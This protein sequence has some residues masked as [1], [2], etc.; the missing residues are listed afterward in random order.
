MKKKPTIVENFNRLAKIT[1]PARRFATRL[2]RPKPLMIAGVCLLLVSAVCLHADD[3]RTWTSRSGATVDASFVKK[4]RGFIE[5]K[6]DTGKRL[7]IRV[8]DLSQDDREYIHGNK[9]DT[10]QP[11]LK[12]HSEK[13][14][15]NNSKGTEKKEKKAKK[16]GND[17][18]PLSL[19]IRQRAAN[20]KARQLERQSE[21]RHEKAEITQER[22]R[23]PRR[24]WT[25]VRGINESEYPEVNNFASHPGAPGNADSDVYR[26][27]QEDILEGP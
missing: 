4:D 14:S 7:M 25:T 10:N 6:A 19:K 17:T 1:L 9:V 2:K 16:N 3:M 20:W 24:Y 15:G 22:K 13:H 8:T 23:L 26:E 27:W 12:K 11:S 18:L 21:I 5:L